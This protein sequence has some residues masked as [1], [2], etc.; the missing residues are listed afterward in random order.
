MKKALV[1]LGAVIA[2]IGIGAAAIPFAED[3]AARRLKEGLAREGVRVETVRIGFLDRSI[4]LSGVAGGPNAE[5]AIAEW[6]ATGLAWPLEELLKGRVPFAGLS[7][8]DPLHVAR[9][10]LRNL[11]LAQPDEGG[12]WT[13]GELTATGVDLPRYD[14]A[15]EGFHRTEVMIARL[16]GALTVDHLEQSAIAHRTLDGTVYSAATLVV[17]GYV[18]GLL[19]KLEVKGFEITAAD[20]RTADLTIAEIAA[21]GLDLRRPIGTASSIDFE[22]GMPIGRVPVAR[23][24]LV[25]FGGDLLGRYGVSLGSIT[26]E[27]STEGTGGSRSRVAVEGFVLAPSLRSVEA[28]GTFMVLQAMNLKEVRLGFSCDTIDDHVGRQFRIQDCALSAPGLVAISLAANVVDTDDE[29]WR[30]IDE[31]DIFALLGT[32]AALAAARL[33]IADKS[34]LQRALQAK[35]TLGGQTLAAE[36]AALATEIR[37]YQPPDVLITPDMSRLQ[38]TIARFVEQGGTLTLEAKP[39]PVLG[40]AKLDYLLRPGADLV[41]ALGLVATLTR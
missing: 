41:S 40:F 9:L 3:L 36:R 34:L 12:A 7:W 6:E 15:Y 32:K 27:T 19:E 37:R 22:P 8:G 25:G 16:L 10:R 20:A 29:F 30:A 35:A 1:A 28:L 23:A 2:L 33:T 24:R 4:R 13:I 38:D 11:R 14:S 5:L 31:T 21:T 39:Q 26:S 18:R 17:G